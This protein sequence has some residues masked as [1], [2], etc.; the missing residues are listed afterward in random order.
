MFSAFKYKI[1][2]LSFCLCL[3][4]SGCKQVSEEP[5]Y[6]ASSAEVGFS[7]SKTSVTEASNVTSVPEQT[8]TYICETA[9]SQEDITEQ[10]ST[11]ST[12]Q[13]S[14]EASETEGTTSETASEET[15]TTTETTTVPETAAVETT[16]AETTTVTKA[17]TTLQTESPSEFTSLQTEPVTV[18]KRP[19]YG[20]NTYSALNYREQ[21]GIWISYLEY[22]IIM[23]NK[24]ASSFKKSIG[25]YFDNIK[26]IG[27]NTVY[28]QVRAHGDAYYDSELFPSGDRFNG[29]MGTSENFDALQIMV[30][31]AHERGLSV[32]AWINPMRLM[33]DEQIKNISDKYLIKQWYNDSAKNGTYIVKH[34]GRWYLNPAYKAVRELIAD[35]ISEILASY[36][37][38]G[39]QIDDYFYPTTAASFDKQAFSALGSSSLSAWRIKNVNSMVKLLYNTVHIA[40]PTAVFGI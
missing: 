18:T 15:T 9:A 14:S 2:A 33:T 13:T 30:D 36:D 35:G 32:H 12:S 23:K 6:S 38:D 1:T 22:D 19:T 24:T 40:N 4:L 29:T 31:E 26:S 5:P 25:K 34:S 39:I 17:Q 16:T 21:K 3:V 10:T 28:V 27:F 37:V 8:T 7:T 11:A 20:T